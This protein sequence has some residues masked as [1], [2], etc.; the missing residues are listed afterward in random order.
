MSQKPLT[1][2]EMLQAVKLVAKTGSV[3]LAA[4]KLGISDG[5][6]HNRL[7]RARAAG[8]GPE[9]SDIEAPI[10][11]EADITVEEMIESMSKRS[12]IRAKHAA[13]AKWMPFKVNSNLPIGLAYIGDPHMDDDGCNWELLRRDCKIM[14]ETPGLYGIG[15]GDYHNNWVGRLQALYASQSATKDDAWRLINWFFKD[16]GINWLLALVDNHDAWNDGTRML[17]EVAKYQ[18]PVVNWR[19]QFKLVFPN[20]RECLIDAAHNFKGTSIW[21]NMHGPLRAAKLGGIAHLYLAGDHHVWGLV[22][23]ECEETNR[24]YNLARA[25]GYKFRDSYA[26]E[27]GFGEQNHGSTVVAIINPQAKSDACFIKCFA[28]LQDGAEYLKYLRK[29][30]A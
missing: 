27:N 15:A 6:L 18:C 24:V 10:F 2:A 17:A 11:P 14:K 26:R 22:Q 16:S 5:A 19:A 13:A 1:P 28:D 20:R 3:V 30:Y 29:V 25:R 8:I 7:R 21:N 12:A 4:E 23:S 9:A